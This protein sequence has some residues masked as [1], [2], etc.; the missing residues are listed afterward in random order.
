M[1]APSPAL[2]GKSIIVTGAGSS[3]GL[4]WATAMLAAA[5]GA[6]V[7]VTD[8]A[9]SADACAEAIVAA[10]GRAQAMTHDVTDE[11][12]WIAVVA[13]AVREFGRVDGLVNNAG[14]ADLARIADMDSAAFRRSLEINL[15]APWMGIRTLLPELRR[16]GAGGSIVNIS[17][18]AGIV[19]FDAATAYS[20]SKGGLRT[21]S[22]AVAIELA[23]EGIRCNSVHPGSIETGM[24][25][26]ASQFDPQRHAA[27]INA[28]PMHKLG[29]PAD[30]A[31]CVCFLLSD[32]A[33]YVTGAEFVVDGGLTA[34]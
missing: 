24:L 1:I 29:R 30:I 6:S 28:V 26:Y 17:S 31:A 20:A 5:Q 32:A 10:G 23:A 12:G 8:L 2:A 21:M 25:K 27:I 22:K 14:I 13:S 33:G 15:T 19:G 7:T 11:A 3:D 18:V 16:H 34:Q 9:T 4:G